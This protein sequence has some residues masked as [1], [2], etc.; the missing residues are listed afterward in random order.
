MLRKKEKAQGLVEFALILPILLLLLLGIVEGARVIWAYITVQTAVREAARYAVSG[1]PYAFSNTSS[2]CLDPNGDPSAQSPWVCDPFS[3]TVAI[4]SIATS[5]VT[6]TLN[7][8]TLCNSDNYALCQSVPN[9]FGVQVIGQYVDPLTPTEVLTKVRHSGTQGLNVRIGAFYNVQM[10]DPIFDRIMG[11]GFIPVRAEISMQNE[12]IDKALGGVPPPAINSSTNITSTGGGGTGP[13]GERIFA[14]NYRVPQLGTLPVRLEN[15]FNLAGPYD[16]YLSQGTPETTF[17]V[18]SG[19]NTDPA[20]NNGDFS[21]FISGAI[22]TG[23]YTLY[24]TLFGDENPLAT[25]TTQQVEIYVSDIA[26]IQVDNGA[27]SNTLVANS[28]AD[29]TL[30]AHQVTNQPYTLTVAYGTPSTEQVIFTGVTVATATN[31]VKNWTVPASLLSPSN[32][33]PSGGTTPCLIHSY[34]KTGLLYATGEFY[35]NQ[36]EIVIAGGLRTFSR[37]EIMH[38]TLRGHAP[39]VQYDLKISDGSGTTQQWLG[40]TGPA[41]ANGQVTVPVDWPIPASWPAG[42]P[43]G[44]TAYTISSHPAQGSV[45]PR[46]VASMTSANQVASLGVNI[47]A[48]PGPY[49]TIDGGY[50]WPAGSVINIQANQHPQGITYYFKFGPWRVPIPTGTPSADFFQTDSNLVFV[51][52]Y[53]IPLTATVGVTTTFVVSSFNNA[54]GVATATVPVTV[55]PVPVIRVLEGSAVAPDTIITIQLL[56]HNPD[57]T[58]H[59]VYLDKLLGDILTNANG[60]GQLKYDLRQLPT[61]SPPGLSTTYGTAYNLFSQ[62]LVGST[63]A[64]TQLTLRAADLRVTSIQVPA[65][66]A[67]NTTIP[68]TFTVQNTSPVTITHY[69]DNDTYFDPSPLTP[70]FVQ[71][72]FNFPGDY[73]YW[74]PPSLAPGATFSFT[75]SYFLGTYGPHSIYG[76]ADTSNLILNELSETNNI[77]SNTLTLACTPTFITD[78]FD[79]GESAWSDQLFGVISTTGI[80]PSQIVNVSSNNRLRLTSNGVSTLRS[81]DNANVSGN[82]PA[83]GYTFVHRTTPITT[84]SGLDVRVQVRATTVSVNGAKFGLEL[85]DP[86]SNIPTNAKLEFDLNRVGSNQYKLEVAYRDSLALEPVVTFLSSATLDLSTPIWLRIQRYGGTNTFLFY[87]AQSTSTP[88]S[89]TLIHSTT[90]GLSNQLEY[91]VFMNDGTQ[92][93]PDTTDFDNFVVGNPA[94]C[95]DAQGPPPENNI[96]PGLATCTNPLG[97]QGFEAT[98][99]T[100][101]FGTGSNGVFVT[102]SAHAG[103]N[104]LLA[105]TNRPGPNNPVFYQRFA[106]PTGLVSGTTTVKLELFKNVD[107]ETDGPNPNDQF[108]V[109]LATSPSLTSAVT[110]PAVVSS[111]DQGAVGYTPANWQKVTLNLQAALGF[112]L[113]SFAGQPLYLYFYDNSNQASGCPPNNCQNTSFYFDDIKLSPCTVQPL[114]PVIT[115]RIQGS[116]VLHP[117]GGST[118]KIAG[119]KVWAYAENGAL[120]ET[121]TIQNGEFNFY[122]L[123]PVNANPG[124]KYFIYAEYFIRSSANP[125]QI[126]ALTGNVSVVLTSLNNNTNPVIAPTLH[127]Y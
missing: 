26:K 10:L 83:S 2:F 19:I 51:A 109:V 9:A 107:Q 74:R 93:T 112:N 100:K 31:T 79:S 1:K 28:I 106:M 21:C 86:P 36:P 111:G 33:C 117:L 13:N 59:I 119:V 46:N 3:R 87:Y 4:E 23:L 70:S 56:N 99:L 63:I 48:P 88:T 90:V 89:W 12:G 102:T 30:V 27:G 42:P 120:F 69:F 60:Q 67:I 8:S 24:S 77:L 22:P 98:P 105:D 72:Q 35:L 75:Q 126:E 55:L 25:D 92:S 71:G 6:S 32:P 40:R 11:G 115:T 94:T 113:A 123:T 37:N 16:I 76:Y 39:G 62:S 96:P 103:N 7:Y 53:R 121:F 64:T 18:C 50:T 125:D 124:I 114:P 110:I 91:G 81:N 45:V 15:H 101:W 118:Q 38:I 49:L 73:K 17:K 84:A 66:P 20:T 61:N 80:I 116:V 44:G 65:N 68:L 29:I 97:E 104:A 5:R 95:P 54:T 34:D 58:Y 41:D 82:K 43:P 122:N 78:T 14:Q 57:T 52:P 85:R 47:K 108:K 127:L